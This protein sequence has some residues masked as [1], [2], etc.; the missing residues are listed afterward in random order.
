MAVK[1]IN[2]DDLTSYIGGES[3][4][5]PAPGPAERGMEAEEDK[6][7]QAAAAA[8]PNDRGNKKTRIHLYIHFLV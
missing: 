2:L 3:P 6:S 4:A 7:D 1:E 5:A 8:V